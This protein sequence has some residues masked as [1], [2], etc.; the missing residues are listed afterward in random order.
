[1]AA[2]NHV[3]VSF[4][5]PEYTTDITATG[6]VRSLEAIR[7]AGIQPRFYQPSPSEMYGLVQ[8]VG[9]ARETR[10]LPG[11]GSGRRV[12]EGVLVLGDGELPRELRDAREQRHSV[13]P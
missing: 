4:D 5:A 6:T 13:Q 12:R 1:M 3:R 9:M 10:A 8:E 7:E 2:Q 11:G